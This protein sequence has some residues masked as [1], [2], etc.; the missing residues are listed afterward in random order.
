MNQSEEDGMLY[1]SGEG[2]VRW[3]CLVY[4]AA[5]AD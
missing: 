4:V 5:V 1:W 3:M 2:G